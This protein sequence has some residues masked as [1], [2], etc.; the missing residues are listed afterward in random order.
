MPP[1]ELF[2]CNTRVNAADD[3]VVAADDNDDDEFIFCTR[4]SFFVG[5]R[6]QYLPYQ[7]VT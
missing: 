7:I 3:G 4:C 2:L 5:F 6:N 1:F